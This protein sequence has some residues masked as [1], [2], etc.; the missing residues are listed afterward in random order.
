MCPSCSRS[1]GTEDL[2]GEGLHE[3]GLNRQADSIEDVCVKSS[4]GFGLEKEAG[5]NKFVCRKSSNE[6][7]LKKQASFSQTVSKFTSDTF[8]RR[9][10]T[11]S[12]SNSGSSPASAPRSGIPTPHGRP[13][14]LHRR[15]SFLASLSALTCSTPAKPE[16][17][18]PASKIRNISTKLAQR[19]FLSRFSSL[20]APSLSPIPPFAD[21]GQRKRSIH[22]TERKLM[23]PLPP[24][25]PRSTTFGALKSHAP[26]GST[27]QTPSYARATSSSQARSRQSG[28]LE[29]S[30]SGGRITTSTSATRRQVRRNQPRYGIDTP[31]PARKVTPQ[32]Y[33]KREIT[34]NNLPG[35]NEYKSVESDVTPRTVKQSRGTPFRSISFPNPQ[36]PGP[37]EIWKHSHLASISS[38]TPD[39]LPVQESSTSDP[40]DEYSPS[41]NE[42]NVTPTPAEPNNPRQITAAQLP[43]YWLGRLT[44]LSDRFRTEALADSLSSS[45][46]MHDDGRRMKRVFIHL[47][48]LCVTEEAKES[49]EKFRVLYE[50]RMGLEARAERGE[51]QKMVFAEMKAKEEGKPERKADGEKEEKKGVFEKLVGRKK[52]AL[53]GKK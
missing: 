52:K 47:N 51:M 40:M 17:Q 4:H 27:P 26:A 9:R 24:P 7:A 12:T 41:E 20:P 43:T 46:G 50:K 11:L 5:G 18:P 53:G 48:S 45:D 31:T 36:D 8:R 38:R 6:N 10:T 25:L 23:A 1:D 28:S 2:S 49:L 13:S 42:R 30:L 44:S 37:K 14:P 34:S 15:P 39:L 32:G 21:G 35:P 3:V 33:L 16:P 29:A 22:I 19:P